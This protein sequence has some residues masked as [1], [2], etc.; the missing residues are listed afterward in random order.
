[1]FSSKK[2]LILL[3]IAICSLI[4]SLPMIRS[5]LVY[6]FGIGFWGPSGHDIIWHLQLIN[7]V[8]NFIQIPLASYSGV[9]LQNYHPFY[10]IFISFV[11]Q[12]TGIKS[13]YL[14]FQI[15]PILSSF[16]YLYLSFL[17]GQKITKTILGGILL[18]F[19]N[20]FSNS[21]GWII[22]LL[23]SGQ[24]AGDSIFWSMQPASFQSNPPL[25]L[26][27]IFL[28]I[29]IFQVISN[30]IN[31]FTI[32]LLCLLPITKA[33][34]GVAGYL[35]VGIYSLFQFFKKNYQPLLIFFMSIPISLYFF[36][37]FN[38]NS[39]SL[40]KYSPFWFVIN[41]FSSVDK[42]YFP[43]ISS[44]I[45]TYSSVNNP[46]LIPILLIGSLIFLIG[47]LGWRFI[48]IFSAL[49]SRR[50]PILSFSALILILLPLF[51]I[52]QGT[53]WNTIQF[54]YYGLILSNILLVDFLHK[55]NKQKYY[56][57][58]LIIIITTSLLAN[59]DIYKNYLGNPPPSAILNNELKAIEFLNTLPQGLILTYPYDPYIKNKI[60]H[61]PIP[62]YA[63]ETNA[64]LGAYTHHY[65]FLADEMNL[66]NSGYDWQTR[67]NQSLE[68]FKQTNIH[69]DRGFLVNNQI[70]YIY[71]TGFQINQTVLDVTN[72]YLTKIYDYQDTIIYRVNR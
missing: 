10:N 46:K 1:M 61:T 5:G 8:K 25:I 54:F 57:Y 26:S 52:Q 17:I 69:Q 72:L 49:K 3:F 35:I 32:L 36:F 56:K 64:Y 63:Y 29:I 34:G 40:I 14:V 33:Y 2:I 48:G 59:I 65:Q 51:F 53:A 27:L 7:H 37:L 6:D 50:H 67:K 11:H 22:S 62:L 68:F 38:Q 39:I 70:D 13:S 24:F 55:N 16:F 19:L 23:R 41:L 15:F 9:P 21:F 45:A 4:Y 31:F 66:N 44:A 42:I 60:P 18:V 71:L 28:M 20:V 43:K 47:N 30:K 58:L 12:F